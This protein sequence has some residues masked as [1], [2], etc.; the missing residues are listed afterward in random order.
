MI[1]TIFE[2]LL[3]LDYK[4]ELDS[5]T[6]HYT[7]VLEN[8]NQLVLRNHFFR[9]FDDPL[10][11]LKSEN[12]PTSIEF[13]SNR[14]LVEANIPIIYGDAELQESLDKPVGQQQIICGIDV[15]ASIFFM[16]ARWE[17]YLD[18][19]RDARNRFVAG[20]SVA[21]KHD[22]LQRPVVNE[23]VEMLWG[24]MTELGISQ[25]RR[26]WEFKVIPTHDVDVPLLSMMGGLLFNMRYIFIRQFRKTRSLPDAFQNLKCILTAK[27]ASI[28]PIKD[29]FDTYDYLMNISESIGAQ[30]RFYFMSGGRES[31]DY[32][33]YDLQS[34]FIQNLFSRIKSRGHQIGFHPSSKSFADIDIWQ[35]EY[36]TITEA[37]PL[38]VKS[39]RQHLLAFEVPTTWQ[40]WEDLGCDYDMTMAYI[41]E[42]GFRCGIC[43][44]FR[45]F[46]ILTREVL[47]IKEI[48]LI[49]MEDTVV[50]YMS[51]SPEETL[52]T[53]L[54]LK[55]TVRKYHGEFVFLWHNNNFKRGKWTRFAHI[56]EVVMKA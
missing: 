6:T 7:I 40:I 33:I 19:N 2:D 51:L 27:V 11:Y 5:S 32:P 37:S 44:P 36:N 30:S 26:E 13:T 31:I 1:R 43:H 12:V 29:P 15:I 20:Q 24:M 54:A 52:R 48:P 3:G 56:Y 35:E 18:K 34:D 45:V 42:S 9:K 38:P 16:L 50:N 14:F 47:H 8:G 25:S 4:I 23:Y 39:G 41:N 21:H 55:D 10:G 22:F 17:E 46:N 49:V 53:M 28:S